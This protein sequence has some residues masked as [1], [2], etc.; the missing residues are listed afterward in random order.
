MNPLFDEMRYFVNFQVDMRMQNEL[1]RKG[2]DMAVN[3][4]EKEGYT[5]KER[6]YRF[7][8]A[9]IDILAQKNG[10][11]A[12]VEVKMRRSGHL[13]SLADAV[14]LKKRS[15]LIKATDHYVITNNLDIEVRFDIILILHSK[16][17]YTLEH[18]EAA[19]SHY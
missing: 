1:G 5:I 14:N 13:R 8:K 7:G 4:L 19:F 6:N 3:W 9:E 12:V 11:L 10:I 16:D 15:R 18:L 2:E 17:K